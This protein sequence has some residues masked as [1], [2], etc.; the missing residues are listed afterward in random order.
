[1]PR[2]LRKP[3]VKSQ[4][5]TTDADKQARKDLSKLKRK[6]LFSGKV[7]GRK[8]TSK[9]RSL[10]AKFSDVIAGRARVFKVKTKKQ[11]NDLK[12]QG[13]EV[14]KGKAIVEKDKL[15]KNGKVFLAGGKK[16]R[17]YTLDLENPEASIFSIW[18]KLQPKYGL[19]VRIERNSGYQLYDTPEDLISALTLGT[20]SGFNLT[21]AIR[22]GAKVELFDPH[23]TFKKFHDEARTKRK[24][25]L[26]GRAT[27]KANKA[28]NKRLRTIQKRGRLALTQGRE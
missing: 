22:T 6:G 16:A 27:R 24:D 21:H 2:K 23:M 19:A 26:A 10:I 18:E 7:R 3:S 14:V 9:L 25:L 4:S 28:A 1:M 20:G 13:I 11:R 12:L 5:S 8:I 15:V 17:I